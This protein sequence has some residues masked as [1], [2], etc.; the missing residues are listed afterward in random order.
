MVNT[1]YVNLDGSLQY[2]QTP[3]HIL[4]LLVCGSF[5][6]KLILERPY[7]FWNWLWI[8]NGRKGNNLYIQTPPRILSLLF[9]GSF[10]VK[11]NL[12]RPYIFWKW[13]GIRK[14]SEGKMTWHNYWMRRLLRELFRTESVSA[15]SKQGII[16]WI[17]IRANACIMSGITSTPW[18]SQ[19]HSNKWVCMF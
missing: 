3:A 16:S 10:L 11:L 12:K 9:C 2:I 5:F 6:M 19:R 4:S 8:R 15:L 13:L 14:G 17:H 1:R 18:S 7:I